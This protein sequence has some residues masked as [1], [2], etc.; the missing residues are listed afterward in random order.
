MACL[1]CVAVGL[2]LLA[3]I[4]GMPALCQPPAKIAWPQGIAPRLVS[5]Q[6]RGIRLTE[7]LKRLREKTGVDVLRP[8]GADPTLD[9]D[10]NGATFW[11][12]LDQI[13]GRADLRLALYREDGKVALAPGPRMAPP[14]SYHG[15]FRVALTEI[16]AGR[17]F[18]SGAHTATARLELVWQP[19][20]QAFLAEV[21]PDTFVVQDDKGQSKAMAPGGR[22]LDFVKG[23]I[24]WETDVPLPAM[25]RAVP[26]LGLLKGQAAVIGAARM[27]TFS[28][29]T[30][31]K[32]KSATQDR[33][34]ANI[35]DFSVRKGPEQHW[36]VTI[37]LRYPPGGPRLESYQSDFWLRRNEIY[38][39][40]K[41]GG[42][43]FPNNG[44]FEIDDQVPHQP[45][46]TYHF[47]DEPDKKLFL[48]QPAD[49][50]LTYRTPSPLL[51]IAVPFEFRNVP[52]P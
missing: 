40:S 15:P 39:V 48:G 31:A 20:F 26:H 23:R 21:R 30:I 25:P 5:I 33:V 47:L 41:N 27:L 38:L 1:R 2:G 51:E 28:F 24:A 42:R 52:L 32:D 37:A 11:Q 3:L 6:D 34:G 4:G 49:W 17:R 10:I 22:G 19:P 13:A 50:K 29:D 18:D 7:A 44:R 35:K 14:V 45:V 9:L 12:A 16:R 8:P 46:I 36:I 43:R